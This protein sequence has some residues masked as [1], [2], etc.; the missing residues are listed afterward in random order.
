MMK[1]PTKTKDSQN[2]HAVSTPR[3]RKSAAA[4]AEGM[5]ATPPLAAP[6]P[7]GKGEGLHSLLASPPPPGPVTDTP[8]GP[9]CTPSGCGGPSAYYDLS[10]AYGSRGEHTTSGNGAGA[11][12]YSSPA[13]L[14]PDTRSFYI[15][16][17]AHEPTATPTDYLGSH[18]CYRRAGAAAG[19][20]AAPKDFTY[21]PGTQEYDAG[22]T[23]SIPAL[24]WDFAA[25][26]ASSPPLAAGDAAT[27]ATSAPRGGPGAR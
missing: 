25:G 13:W 15:A 12:P 4:N 17:G 14:L 9:G 3:G 8:R 6:L 21:A 2:G 11:P 24:P 27:A 16:P 23:S 26:P 10:T 7:T 1:G 22:A 18:Y 5:L 20:P 19:H